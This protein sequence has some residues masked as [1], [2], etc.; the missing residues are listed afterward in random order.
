MP[1]AR[2]PQIAPPV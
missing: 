2:H 1:L